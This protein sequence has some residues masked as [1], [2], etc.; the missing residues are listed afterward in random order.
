MPYTDSDPVEATLDLTGKWLHDP[1]DPESTAYNF[2]YG[3]GSEASVDA[4]GVGTLYAG[5]EFPVYDYGEHEEETLTASVQVPHGPTHATDLA[6]LAT[7]ARA[8]RTLWFRDNR[9]RSAAS[10]ITSFKVKDERWGSLVSLTLARL[11]YAVE[12]VSA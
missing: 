5:R 10:T 11:D 8:K 12:E 3:P 4:A 6:A 2:P 9:G 7:F 1:L